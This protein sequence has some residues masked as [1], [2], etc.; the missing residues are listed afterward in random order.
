M[1]NR[2]RDMK[3]AVRWE[4]CLRR[5]RGGRGGGGSCG[6]DDEWDSCQGTSLLG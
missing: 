3:E 5:G 2:S 4:G 6:N 1:K